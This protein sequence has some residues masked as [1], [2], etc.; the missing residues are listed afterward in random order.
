MTVS[1]KI[2]D[3]REKR[4]ECIRMLTFVHVTVDWRNEPSISASTLEKL[5][6]ILT[7]VHIYLV[8]YATINMLEKEWVIRKTS[9]DRCPRRRLTKYSRSL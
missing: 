5:P 6:W 9:E 3:F 2:R 1:R 7:I 4:S 8:S